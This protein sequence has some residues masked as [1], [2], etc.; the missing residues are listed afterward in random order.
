MLYSSCSL[1]QSVT[2]RE[3]SL[4]N[5]ALLSASNAAYEGPLL[6]WGNE[7]GSYRDIRAF[8]PLIAWAA[9]SGTQGQ[10]KP[11]RPVASGKTLSI[12]SCRQRQC[13]PVTLGTSAIN[14]TPNEHVRR[15]TRLC[16]WVFKFYF[17]LSSYFWT[18]RAC[19]HSS[20]ASAFSFFVSL[21]LLSLA[22]PHT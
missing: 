4:F 6:L 22:L 18:A 10:T 15:V 17:S 20:G 8:P 16:D 3:L 21:F 2:C 1:Q 13:R 12:Q 9:E 11:Y 14:G 19:R 5:E 7:P